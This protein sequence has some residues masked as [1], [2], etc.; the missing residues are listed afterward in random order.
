MMPSKTRRTLAVALAAA[1][2]AAAP[3]SAFATAST[4]DLRGENAASQSLTAPATGDL[5]GESAAS[6]SV[7]GTG[8][9]APSAPPVVVEVT[10]PVSGGFDWTAA[11]IGM[12]AGL[13]L[14]VLAG[15]GVAGG[16]H[17]P[18]AA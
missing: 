14:A 13:A 15:V 12:S 4:G 17:R 18:S 1:S 10:K 6:Q 8:V 11:I 7:T 5:R 2:L 16:R 3:T 9:G